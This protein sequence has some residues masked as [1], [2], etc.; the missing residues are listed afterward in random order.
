MHALP[1]ALAYSF[2]LAPGLPIFEGGGKTRQK[3]TIPLD[4]RLAVASGT[5]DGEIRRM[6]FEVERMG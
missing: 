3:L 2:E 6:R 4:R 1:G 5:L